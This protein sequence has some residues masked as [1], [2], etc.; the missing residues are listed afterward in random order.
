MYYIPYTYKIEF[1]PTGQYYY[2]VRYAKNCHPDDLWITYF[3]SSKIIHNLIDK[4]GLDEFNV[5]IR[6]IFPNNPEKAKLWEHKVLIKLNIPHNPQYLNCSNGVKFYLPEGYKHSIETKK[7]MSVKANLPKNTAISIENLKKAVEKNIGTKRTNNFIKQVS[8]ENNYMFGKTH[9]E[10]AKEVMSMKKTGENNPMYG[11]THSNKSIK[12]MK[13]AQL[14]KIYS[15][16][17]LEKMSKAK[18]NQPKKSCI[19]C[20]LSTTNYGTLSRWHNNNCKHK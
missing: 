2:G 12:K 19:H 9:S 10:Q 17:T 14:G 18:L 8:G 16:V 3:T 1:K 13:E 20:G 11:R 5:E 4:H 7:K 6:K 15:N